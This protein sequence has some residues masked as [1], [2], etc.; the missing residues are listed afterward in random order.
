MILITMYCIFLHSKNNTIER[1]MWTIKHLLSVDLIQMREMQYISLGNTNYQSHRNNFL[2]MISYEAGHEQ[3]IKKC[4]FISLISV[5][6]I[7]IETKN[8]SNI[9]IYSILISK[10]SNALDHKNISGCI[11]YLRKLH[12]PISFTR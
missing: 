12:V 6:M 10:I 8:V 3:N 7:Y 11:W 5:I 9:L 2:L 4:F 1:K